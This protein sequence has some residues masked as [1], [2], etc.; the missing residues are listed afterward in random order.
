MERVEFHRYHWDSTIHQ[1]NLNPQDLIGRI[2]YK[3]NISFPGIIRD[4]QFH[5][6]RHSIEV[7]VEW[8]RGEEWTDVRNLKCLEELI[9]QRQKQL[10]AATKGYFLALERR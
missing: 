9:E 2:V 4:V 6:M 1:Y 7:L 10:E 5:G 8:T 3:T